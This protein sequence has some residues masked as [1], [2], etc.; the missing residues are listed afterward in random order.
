MIIKKEHVFLLTSY[1][2]IDRKF[3]ALEIQSLYLYLKG[4]FRKEMWD[5]LFMT[6]KL[7][8]YEATDKYFSIK[9]L[10]S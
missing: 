3:V 9:Q 8:I 6:M 7:H 1:L 5:N 2:N 10:K 4:T